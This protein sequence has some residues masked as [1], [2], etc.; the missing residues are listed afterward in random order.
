M[1]KELEYYLSL[2]YPILVKKISEDDGGGFLAEIPDLPG[3]MSDG[4]TVE[5]AI[6][7]VAKAKKK[8][9]SIT[10]KRGL[11]IPLPATDEETYSGK[12]TLRIPRSL[13]RELSKRAKAEGMSLNQY[14][15]ALLS[16]NL[17]FQLGSQNQAATK[18]K[19]A[20]TYHINV[21]NCNDACRVGQEKVKWPLHPDGRWLM[22]DEVDRVIQFNR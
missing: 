5:E 6:H 12:F 2:D 4:E 19:G 22:E 17:G 8:W 11:S 9:I 21:I 13:H 15:L 14:V 10:L 20:H 16:Y 7:N 18:D 1:S 3:C